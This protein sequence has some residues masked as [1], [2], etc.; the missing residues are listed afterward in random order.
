MLIIRICLICNW[1]W[2]QRSFGT[3]YETESELE[4]SVFWLVP[5]H[6]WPE[7]QLHTYDGAPNLVNPSIPIKKVLIDLSCSFYLGKKHYK[8]NVRWLQLHYRA[9]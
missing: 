4:L 7:S 3:K 8:W 6:L 9:F 1:F 2:D 5:K